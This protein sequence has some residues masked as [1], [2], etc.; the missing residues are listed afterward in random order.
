MFVNSFNYFRGVAILVIVAGHC[1]DLADIKD[2]A[3][4]E[5]FIRNLMSGGSALFVFISGFMFHHV[6]FEN[7]NYRRF[8]SNKARNVLLP[9]LLLS[10]LPIV[11]FVLSRK[12][13]FDGFFLPTGDGVIAEYVVPYLKYLWTGVF[14][15]PYWYIACIILIFLLSP[16]QVA[17]IR[18]GPRL[19]LTIILLALVAAAFLHRPVDNLSQLQSVGYFLPVYLLGIQCSM[20]KDWVYKTFAGR[21]LILLALVL[22]PLI[23]QTL[24]LGHVGTYNKAP[25][26]FGGFDWVLVQKVF[27]C[28]FLM[29]L[30]HRF[31][32]RSWK[33]LGLLASSSFAIYFLHAWVLAVAYDIKDGRET[34]APAF[35]VWPVATA[36]VT[37]LSIGAALVA[38]RILGKRSR[39]VV[40]W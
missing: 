19:R 9:Y 10:A 17:F 6:F 16:L 1:L 39:M 13:H 25:F 26:T 31:E 32:D 23:W 37:A 18:L 21:E 2:E 22:A 4:A 24:V 40:G 7:F 11:Y 15:I 34:G 5:Q 35:L 30:L 36:L 3:V 12:T 20:H 38:R 27:L 33:L 29:V 14:F 8:V 28:L